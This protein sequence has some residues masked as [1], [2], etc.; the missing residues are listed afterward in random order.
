MQ[1]ML[2]LLKLT[3]AFC[4]LAVFAPETTHFSLR[5]KGDTS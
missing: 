4:G 1:N 3:I 2:P 5:P